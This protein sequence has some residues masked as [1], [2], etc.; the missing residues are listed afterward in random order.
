MR[1]RW[2][3]IMTL[4]AVQVSIVGKMQMFQNEDIIDAVPC[5]KL[6]H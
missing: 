2:L 6:F 4:G 5:A 3:L 1:D